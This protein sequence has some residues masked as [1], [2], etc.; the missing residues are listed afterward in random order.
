MMEWNR[1]SSGFTQYC[2]IQLLALDEKGATGEMA[3]T[4]HHL[5]PNGGVHGGALYSLADTI[6]GYSS[7]AWGTEH[8]HKIPG[9]LACTTI[10]GNLNFLRQAKGSKLTCR[11]DYRKMGRTVAVVDVSIRDDQGAETCS[12]TFTF[13]FVDRKRFMKV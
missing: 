3:L 12:G 8:L 4:E 1:D 5:N 9:E 10:T 7:V 2:G 13:M 11:A 6:G